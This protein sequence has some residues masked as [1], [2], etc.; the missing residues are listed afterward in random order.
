MEE[1]EQIRL[2][3]RSIE[4]TINRMAISLA[5]LLVVLSV[6]SH[7]IYPEF[8]EAAEIPNLIMEPD[9]IVK[10]KI[11]PLIE[12]SS[13]VS[14]NSQVSEKFQYKVT[15]GFDSSPLEERQS[16]EKTESGVK[17]KAAKELHI[18]LDSEFIKK[19]VVI[20][21]KISPVV[22]VPDPIEAGV[23]FKK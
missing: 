19:D 18:A 6:V 5:V 12:D 20:E 4:K 13:E 16:E 23:D 8:S 11:E 22:G 17:Y 10:D 14:S 1:I 3:M 2:E 9:Y 21:E 7:L 15:K